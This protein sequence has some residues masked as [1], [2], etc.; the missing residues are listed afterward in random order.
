MWDDVEKYLIGRNLYLEVS[1]LVGHYPDEK[2]TEM[3]L[4]HDSDKLIFGSDAP[5]ADPKETLD[6]FLA[7]KLPE[8]LQNKI[9]WDNAVTLLAIELVT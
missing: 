4:K 1:F 3:L 8:S 9:L 5:W 6:R 7:L 2:V